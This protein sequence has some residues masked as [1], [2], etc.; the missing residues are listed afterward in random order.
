MEEEGPEMSL[1]EKASWKKL[2]KLVSTGDPL[3]KYRKEE[4]IGEGGLGKVFLGERISNKEK[5]AIKVLDIRTYPNTQLITTE[6]INE[7][8]VMQEFSHRNTPEYYDS[9]IVGKQLWIVMEFIEGVGLDE[10]IQKVYLTPHQIACIC[11]QVLSVLKH[12]HAD[13]WI[14]RDIKSCNIILTRLG[15]VKLIDFGL[16][17]RDTGKQTGRYGTPHWLAPEMILR[18]KYNCSVDM[19]SFGITVYEMITGDTP[20]PEESK[21]TAMELIVQNGTPEIPLE[22]KIFPALL[23]ILKTCLQRNPEERISAKRL[24]R[25]PFLVNMKD[26]CLMH[27]R[28][29]VQEYDL[30]TQ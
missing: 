23:T 3:Q 18:E 25:H 26:E 12:L 8:A 13:N 4:M 9:Y 10:V 29:A 27:V 22:H 5:V 17:A 1:Q 28:D 21:E 20:Y 7:V 2:E 6:L 19:W 11:R 24:L 30:K 14:H 15:H 16:V